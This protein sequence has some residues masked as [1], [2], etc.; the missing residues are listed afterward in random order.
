MTSRQQGKARWDSGVGAA[1]TVGASDASPTAGRSP[2]V[3]PPCGAAT[4]ALT[5]DS[6]D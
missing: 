3:R 2:G 5:L 4:V 1:R 6:C